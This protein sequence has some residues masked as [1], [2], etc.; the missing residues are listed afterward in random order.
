MTSYIAR[1]LLLLGLHQFATWRNEAAVSSTNAIP[2]AEVTDVGEPDSQQM[3][4][5][6]NQKPAVTLANWCLAR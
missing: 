2:L 5:A 4:P 1:R 6:D 3:P